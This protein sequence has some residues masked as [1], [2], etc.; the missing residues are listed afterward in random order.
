MKLF[1]CEKTP[2][3]AFAGAATDVLKQGLSFSRVVFCALTTSRVAGENL[4]LFLTRQ[5][6]EAGLW[7][8]LSDEP[9]WKDVL[10]VVP[11]ELD[12]RDLSPN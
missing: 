3:Q 7:E 8:T 10:R 2:L 1:I 5:A 12:E 4:D 6:A 11:I 9:D